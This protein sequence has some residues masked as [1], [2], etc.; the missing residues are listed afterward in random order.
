MSNPFDELLKGMA[1]QHVGTP[2]KTDWRDGGESFFIGDGQRLLATDSG[3][4]PLLE[5]QTIVLNHPAQQTGG[6]PS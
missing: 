5:V 1:S 3:E 4:F 6:T 2:R